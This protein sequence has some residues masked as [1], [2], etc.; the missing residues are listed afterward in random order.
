MSKINNE[1]YI[2]FINKCDLDKKINLEDIDNKSI[3]YGNTVDPDGLNELKNKI[4]EMFRFNEIKSRN[5]NFLSNARDIALV[6]KSLIS[7]E[8]S[9]ESVNMEVPYEMIASDI[10]EAYMN[11]SE[12]VGDTTDESVIDEMFKKFCVGK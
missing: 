7:I 5:Y 3:I 10:A 6:K 2:V 8:Q 11:L 9:I 12:I 1:H 4:K